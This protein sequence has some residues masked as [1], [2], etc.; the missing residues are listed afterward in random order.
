MDG[1]TQLIENW[2]KE[3]GTKSAT[4]RV[5]PSEDVIEVIYSL[6]DDWKCN[7]EVI[8]K[9]CHRIFEFYRAEEVESKVFSLQFIPSLMYAYLS[10][11]AQGDKKDVGSIQTFLLAVYNIE[12][13]DEPQNPK[14]HSFR[15]P[16]IA[17]PSLYHEPLG[18]ASS[19]LTESSLRRLDP[20][21]RIMVKFGPHPHLHSFNAENR[22]PALAA[23]LRIYSHYLMMYSKVSLIE[24]CLAFS[25]LVAQGYTPQSEGSPRIPVS[26]QLLVEILHILYSLTIE[27]GELANRARQTLEVVKQ[28][29]EVELVAA[30]LLIS[31]ALL[32]SSQLSIK[33]VSTSPQLVSSAANGSARAMWKSMI[34]NASFR[35]K[36][37]PDDIT[38]AQ[39]TEGDPAGTTGAAAVSTASAPVPQL[40]AITEEHDEPIVG[41]VKVKEATTFRLPE[42]SSLVK[43]KSKQPKIVKTRP[44]NGTI[45]SNDGIDQVSNGTNERSDWDSGVDIELRRRSGAEFC[46]TEV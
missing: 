5:I 23:L 15:V 1:D 19:S 36:K 46:S 21:N 29:V 37:L 28:R 42:F 2:L 24:S 41:V 25:R 39:V 14:S 35:T 4:K 6:I 8:Q 43:K 45:S 32:D 40:G 17:Q 20:A 16:N 31:A 13:G 38:V 3:S 34:T 7:K 27:D 26:S 9:L 44:N 11:I 18:L 10:G 30:P 12:A 33:G 22:L